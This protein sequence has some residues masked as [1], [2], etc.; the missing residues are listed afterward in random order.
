MNSPFCRLGN[1]GFNV[2]AH[3]R[4][5]RELREVEDMAANPLSPHDFAVLLMQA[6]L[7]GEKKHASGIV[8]GYTDISRE[9]LLRLAQDCVQVALGG[10][11]VPAT[12]NLQVGHFDPIPPGPSA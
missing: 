3:S 11:P 2:L 12:L 5:V 4:L 1:P 7:I 9:E 10:K 6:V 8:G